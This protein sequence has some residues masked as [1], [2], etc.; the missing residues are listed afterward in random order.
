MADADF[1]LV[2]FITAAIVGAVVVPF[3]LGKADRKR[4]TRQIEANDGRVIE[5]LWSWDSGSRYERS[6]NV[7]YITARGVRVT[8]TCRTN[9]NGVYWVSDLPPDD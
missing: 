4:I 7:S 3:L 2:F 1:T 8:A 5:I 6:Y 9:M